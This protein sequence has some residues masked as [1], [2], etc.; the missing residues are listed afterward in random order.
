MSNHSLVAF[1]LKSLL[2]TKVLSL[3]LCYGERVTFQAL[4]KVGGDTWGSSSCI[5]LKHMHKVQ[6]LTLTSL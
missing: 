6:Q 4:F 1:S 3:I 5:Y 2:D